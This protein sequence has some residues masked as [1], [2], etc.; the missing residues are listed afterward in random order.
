MYAARFAA[1]SAAPAGSAAVSAAAMFVAMI[2]AFVGS[3]QMC[4]SPSRTVTPVDAS[5]N[6]PVGSALRI[7]EDSQP[8]SPTPFSTIT[9]A[10]PR[11]TRSAADASKSCGST[12]ALSNGWTSTR[13]P[14]MLRAKSLTCVVVATTSSRP[15]SS[16]D[17]GADPHA[18]SP[19][20]KATTASQR[21]TV[22]SLG[23]GSHP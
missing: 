20:A 10:R 16:D 5:T 21:I 17:R 4:G 3:V 19:T 14:P 12:F 6:E 11:A 15:S 8:S 23:N 9:S 7:V 18:D 2:S 1:Y 13:S 22:P